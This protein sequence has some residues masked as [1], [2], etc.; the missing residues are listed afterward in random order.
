[1][2]DRTFNTAW[3]PEL[4]T[5]VCIKLTPEI[6]QAL[7]TAHAAGQQLSL[8]LTGDH[9]PAEVRDEGLH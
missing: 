3:E 9:G 8:K 1:M 5:A 7:L 2:S 4:G 6:K